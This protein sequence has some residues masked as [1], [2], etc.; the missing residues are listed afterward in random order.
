MRNLGM[1]DRRWVT[2]VG[3]GLLLALPVAQAYGQDTASRL[4][5]TGYIGAVL[6]LS[7]LA[8]QGDTLKAELSTE[9]LF[10]VSLDYRLSGNW[11]IQFMGGYAQP[12]L[13]L[14]SVDSESGFPFSENLGSVDYLHGEATI[15]YRPQ[16]PGAAAAMLPYFGVGVGIRSLSF[17]DESGLEDSDDITF[18]FT[19]GSHVQLSDRV[20]LRLDIRDLVSSFDSAGL[21]ESKVQNE[22]LVNV[23]LGIGL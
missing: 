22:F 21:D 11:G 23:G 17:S 10:G 15:L 19:A 3:A 14:S 12:E 7:E 5:L 16:L 9:P 18:V 6:P 20:H 1:M 13:T 8:S 4:E 2:I